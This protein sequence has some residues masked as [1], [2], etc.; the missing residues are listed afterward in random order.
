MNALYS[1]IFVFALVLIPLVGVGAAHLQTFFGVCVPLTA[2]IIFLAGFTFKILKWVKSPVPYRIPT[3]GGQQQSLDWIKQNKWDNPSTGPQTVMRMILEVLCFRSLFRNTRVEL[4]K[5]AGTVGYASDKWLWVFAIL[6][7]YGFVMIFFR[8]FR[9]FMNPV[10]LPLTFLEFGDGIMQIGVPTF[11]MS[12]ALLLVGALLLLG[13]RLWDAKVRYISLVADY[14]P[15][16][17]IIGIAL[18]GIY[19]RYFVK[20]DIISIKDVTMGLVTGHFTDLPFDKINVS[21]FVH[22]FMVSTLMIYFPFSKLMH[23]GGVFLSPTRNLPNDTR[24][25]HHENPWNPDIKPHS[26]A[27][28]EKEFGVPM[29]EAGL[30]LDD[31]EN[32]KPAEEREG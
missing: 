23:L 2:V 24:M 18:S 14:F 5:D 17:L 11:Y 32:A 31:P 7:H 21:F 28:Y 25:R 12:D 9:L 30:P 3:T 20:V 15:L 8:H 4:N 22:V 27:S 16:L 19:M 10:P 26:Y 1:L 13:R 6:F 29:A